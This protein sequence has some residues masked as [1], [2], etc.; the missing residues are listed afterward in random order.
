METSPDGQRPMHTPAAA[1]TLLNLTS[2]PAAEGVSGTAQA[3]IA[4]QTRRLQIGANWFFLDSR[5]VDIQ[6]GHR[7]VKRPLE[8]PCRAWRYPVHRRTGTL[9]NSV[10]PLCCFVPGPC[11]SRRRGALRSYGP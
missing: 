8:L 4:D 1:L 5:A 7:A 2:P 6:L 3:E 10:A 9:E 11:G